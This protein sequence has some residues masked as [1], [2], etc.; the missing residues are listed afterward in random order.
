MKLSISYTCI[1]ILINTCNECNY[2]DVTNIPVTYMNMYM[3]ITY[4]QQR[5][6]LHMEYYRVHVQLYTLHVCTLVLL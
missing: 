1:R 6:T 4:N 3:Y 5:V 2:H